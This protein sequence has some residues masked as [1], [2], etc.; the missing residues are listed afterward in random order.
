MGASLF[1]ATESISHVNESVQGVVNRWQ[2]LINAAWYDLSNLNKLV[3]EVAYKLYNEDPEVK[4]NLSL[5]EDTEEWELAVYSKV[6]TPTQIQRLVAPIVSEWVG[7]IG[8]NVRK[9]PVRRGTSAKQVE[10]RSG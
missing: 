4:F 5:T 9:R 1:S 6:L 3:S 7:M 8:I 2:N 10:A